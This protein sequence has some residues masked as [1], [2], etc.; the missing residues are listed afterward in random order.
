ML[1]KSRAEKRIL[2]PVRGH[3]T[4]ELCDSEQR[5][6]KMGF[7]CKNIWWKDIK[8]IKKSVHFDNRR[9]KKIKKRVKLVKTDK[10]TF[11]KTIVKNGAEDFYSK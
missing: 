4:I 8:C 3:Q 1:S 10:V 6:E 7:N 5:S 11:E 2:V 9:T